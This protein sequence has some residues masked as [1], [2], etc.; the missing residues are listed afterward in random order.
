MRQ[1]WS[2]EQI[3]EEISA[4]LSGVAEKHGLTV[5]SPLFSCMALEGIASP[6]KFLIQASPLTRDVGLKGTDA[7]YSSRL[8]RAVFLL[9]SPHSL[10]VNPIMECIASA[11][12]GSTAPLYRE[13]LELRT[14]RYYLRKPRLTKGGATKAKL[15]NASIEPAFASALGYLE[16]GGVVVKSDGERY[17]LAYELKT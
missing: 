11:L 14:I 3:R 7:Y 9:Q 13:D 2:E 8:A 15:A 10:V 6:L 12:R 5:Y 4:A 1:F 17:E 16:S